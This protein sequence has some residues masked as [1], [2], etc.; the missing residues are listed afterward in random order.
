M[1]SAFL[2]ARVII[3]IDYRQKGKTIND[4]NYAN[5]L[6]RFSDKTREKTA[7]FSVKRKVGSSRQCTSSH[8]RY[9]DGQNQ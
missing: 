7:A 9:I 3:F 5:L 8:I 1:T 2:D 4:V 6:Q